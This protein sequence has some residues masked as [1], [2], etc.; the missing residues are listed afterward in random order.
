MSKPED[1]TATAG[2]AAPNRFASGAAF[3]DI[4]GDAIG[5]DMLASEFDGDDVGG[6]VQALR[7]AK[8]GAAEAVG[9][10]HM[11]AHGNGEHADLALSSG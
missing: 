5:I 2:V 3:A 10:H 1:I 8:H 6:A 4:D 7:R 11:V 9:D